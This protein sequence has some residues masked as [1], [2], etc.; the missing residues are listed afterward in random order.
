MTDL[1]ERVFRQRIIPVARNLEPSRA[2]PLAEA[3]IASDIPVLEVTMESENVIET[4]RALQTVDAEVGAGTV[5]SIAQA[6]QA[7]AAGASFLV[8]PHLDEDLTSWAIGSGVS[9]LPG[10][11]TPTEVARALSLGVSA[12]KLFPASIGGPE[13][14]R[15]L[16]GPFPD[17]I[18]IPTGG[19]TDEN[20]RDFLAAGAAAVGVGGWL[21]DHEDLGVI[22]ARARRLVDALRVA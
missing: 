14:V 15:A 20:A 2:I 22:T 17:L 18:V 7:I 11:F 16:R 1:P 10:V 8:S 19:I 12:V 4:I 21:T 6:E 9:Y 5:T 3:L 13:A